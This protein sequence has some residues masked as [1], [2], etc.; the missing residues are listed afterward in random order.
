MGG[1]CRKSR[2]RPKS[3]RAR[4]SAHAVSGRSRSNSWP[5]QVPRVNFDSPTLRRSQRQQ[6]GPH[7]LLCGRSSSGGG[8]QPVA[9]GCTL[10]HPPSAEVSVS[11]VV[12][13]KYLADH[14]LYC[15][16]SV[17]RMNRAQTRGHPRWSAAITASPH[18]KQCGPPFCHPVG[19]PLTASPA[20]RSSSN[21]ASLK[22]ARGSPLRAR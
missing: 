17:R 20:L 13:T 7:S 2:S 19:G 10:R 3:A 22:P 15:V 16:A 18:S 9:P 14:L 5:R 4:W 21:P 11:R 1:G 6:G 8:L 12:H